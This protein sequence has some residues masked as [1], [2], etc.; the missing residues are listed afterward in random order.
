[1]ITT[2]AELYEALDDHLNIQGDVTVGFGY[3][4]VTVSRARIMRECD[5]VAYRGAIN[6]YADMIGVDTDELEGNDDR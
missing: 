6:D 3:C 4:E 5:P 2:W 1:M